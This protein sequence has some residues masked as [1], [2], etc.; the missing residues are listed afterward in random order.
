MQGQA[1]AILL[2]IAQVM[3]SSGADPMTSAMAGPGPGTLCMYQPGVPKPLTNPG[4]GASPI[5]V[6]GQAEAANDP[7]A[8]AEAQLNW[9]RK[10]Q[11]TFGPSFAV[12]GRARHAAFSCRESG[13]YM[14]PRRSCSVQAQPC[15]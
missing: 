12:F 10:V 14:N 13:S 8:R 1:I 11:A 15:N 4:P 7:G 2:S 3:A 9:S 5:L 6:T